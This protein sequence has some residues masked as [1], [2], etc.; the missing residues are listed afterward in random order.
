MG[1]RHDLAGDPPAGRPA[2]RLI[3]VVA[4]DGIP[5]AETDA[6]PPVPTQLHGHDSDT[7]AVAPGRR[8]AR[9]PLRSSL[10]G[11]QGRVCKHTRTSRALRC[12]G[13]P[14]QPRPCATNQS[15]PEGI[16]AVS[17]S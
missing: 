8:W 5:P 6:R 12:S 1:V 9:W 2:D 14:S 4:D 7:P 13:A 10:T 11:L 3:R 16:S 17:L 15:G